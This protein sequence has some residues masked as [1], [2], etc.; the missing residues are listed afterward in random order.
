MPKFKSLQAVSVLE[1]MLINIKMKAAH[2][3]QI[4][5][6]CRLWGGGK[7]HKAKNSGPVRVDLTP[8]GPGDK[9]GVLCTK[10]CSLSKSL[11]YLSHRVKWAQILETCSTACHVQCLDANKCSASR[12]YQL[13][14]LEIRDAFF[15]CNFIL[16]QGL[17]H[18]P[19]LVKA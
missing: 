13:V 15:S 11:L 10:P 19:I 17:I 4:G 16:A 9:M 6:S 2:L 14:Y 7:R 5:F 3:V 18:L 8:C 1:P 12:D